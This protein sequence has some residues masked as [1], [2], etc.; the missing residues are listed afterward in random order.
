MQKQTLSARMNSMSMDERSEALHDI[1]GVR[2]FDA[3]II[4]ETPEFVHS[5]LQE[6]SL[7]LMNIAKNTSTGS[8]LASIVS[9]SEMGIQH[10]GFLA[11]VSD[12]ASVDHD[13]ATSYEQKVAGATDNLKFF[14]PT[15]EWKGLR[16]RAQI[17]DCRGSFSG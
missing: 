9:F 3:S 2:D 14:A 1:H 11:Q 10:V 7:C 8:F 5:K 13:Q 16:M 4:Q 15:F 12:P 6:L 17:L